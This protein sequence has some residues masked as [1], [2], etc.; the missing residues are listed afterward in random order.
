M[1]KPHIRSGPAQLF[2]IR[3]GPDPFPLQHILLLVQCFAQ[4]RMQAH[5]FLPGQH[6]GFAEQV[7]RNGERGAWRQ[8][9]PPH[10][11][12][13]TVMVPVDKMIAVLQDFINGL[14]HAVRRQPA[15]LDR[16]VHGPAGKMHPDAQQIRSGRLCADQVTGTAGE[17]VVVIKHGGTAVFD[18]LTHAGQGGQEDRVRVQVF[19]DLIKRLQPVK[20]LH[21]LHFFQV[22]G[23]HLVQV[24][25]GVDQPRIAKHTAA[26]N[27][28]VRGPR[29]R[30]DT[31]NQAVFT[32]QVNLFIDGV[33]P[34][35]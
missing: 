6:R 20:Q 13:G 29:L 35:A 23:E 9:N 26:V 8:G 7:F 32:I 12:E 16:K 21:V 10:G 25:M 31:G 34:V 14:H 4:V 18:Q 2:H 17:N 24:V 33:V 27:H 1:G 15:V 19:P 5:P 28:G 11:P 3:Q 30:P 22:P